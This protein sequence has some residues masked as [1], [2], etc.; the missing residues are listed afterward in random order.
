MTKDEFLTALTACAGHY[1]WHVG[2]H[3]GHLRAFTAGNDVHCPLTALVV[4]QQQPT[5]DEIT[6]GEDAA[7]AIGLGLCLANALMHA[8]DK[9]PLHDPALRQALLTAVGL[10]GAP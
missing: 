10:G 4:A 1:R 5:H 6:Y 9:S 3:T 7:H 2:E 8:A